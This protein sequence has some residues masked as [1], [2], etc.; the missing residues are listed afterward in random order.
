MLCFSGGSLQI[1]LGTFGLLPQ[2]PHFQ[3][4]HYKGIFI[5]R[6]SSSSWL[7]PNT[8]IFLHST[9]DS[10]P[11]Q[12]RVYHQLGKDC[13]HAT[14]ADGASRSYGH[15]NKTMGNNGQNPNS[16]S[17][18]RGIPTPSVIRNITGSS[19]LIHQGVHRCVPDGWDRIRPGKVLC[20][21]GPPGKI[22][23]STCSNLS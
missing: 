9:F 6:Q 16:G 2:S 13:P 20:G 4:L 15:F 21:L 18:V 10:V 17:P 3:P 1:Q 19:D 12:V 7:G 22:N 14:P 5:A 11:S 23:T 8:G